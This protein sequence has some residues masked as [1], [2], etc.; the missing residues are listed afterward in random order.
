[1]RS[2]ILLQDRYSASSSEIV[3]SALRENLGSGVRTLGET[4]YGKGI[5]QIYVPTS[6]G[7][8]MAVTCLHLDPIKA[9]R[10]HKIGIDPDLAIDSA[11]VTVQAWNLASA[12]KPAARALGYGQ[13]AWSLQALDWNRMETGSR[14]HA[15]LKPAAPWRPFPVR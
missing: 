1:G 9:P 11:D 15:P 7:G 12:D 4:S 2:I 13:P 5:G 6:L 3:I 14:V 10:Y 8:F